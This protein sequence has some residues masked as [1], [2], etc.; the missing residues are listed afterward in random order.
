MPRP[1]AI[2]AGRGNGGDE[3]GGGGRLATCD[4]RWAGKSDAGRSE[5]QSGTRGGAEDAERRGKPRIAGVS[6]VSSSSMRGGGRRGRCCYIERVQRTG[7][8]G[9]RGGREASNIADFEEQGTPSLIPVGKDQYMPSM[10]PGAGGGG[11]SFLGMSATM[12]SVT[13]RR[14]AMLAALL[15]LLA[16]VVGGGLVDLA[17]ELGDA[18]LDG[19]G[20]VVV[21]D[22]GGVSPCRR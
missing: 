10:P 11:G 19:G 9:R 2:C 8:A 13:R 3:K 21:G 17:G 18:G 1:A 15:E 5:G 16:V 12:A 7:M 22:D 14:P 4:V 6:T 20:V